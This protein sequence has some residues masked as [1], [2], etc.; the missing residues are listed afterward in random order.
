MDMERKKIIYA[1]LARGLL[2]VTIFL[3][4][5]ALALAIYGRSAPFDGWGFR[6]FPIAVVFPYSAMGILVLARHPG[7]AVG[8]I[9][10][11]GSFFS[12]L[13]GLLFEYMLYGLVLF[14]GRLPGAETVAWILNSYWVWLLMLVVLLLVVFPDGR[15]PSPRWRYFIYASYAGATAGVAGLSFGPGPLTS[16]FAALDNPYALEGLAFP[17]AQVAYFY[18]I[19]FFALAYGISVVGLV[20]RIRRSQGQRRQQFKW[21]AYAAVL[22]LLATPFSGW[23]IK[24]LEFIHMVAILLL[25]VAIAIAILRH[26]LYDIDLLIRRTLVYSLLSAILVSVYF[27]TVVLA[28]NV[29]QGVTGQAGQSPLAVVASTLVIA[30]LFTPLR[31]RIQ[32]LIDRRFFRSKYDTDQILQAFSGAVRDEVDLE[33][34]QDH[35]VSVVDETMQPEVVSLWLQ[36]EDNPSSAGPNPR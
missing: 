33:Q 36:E 1:R 35:L 12:A 21:F 18:V 2:M 31:R 25:P 19:G 13:Q 29:I 3:A 32:D 22:L 8:W 30:A 34:L 26:N 20:S 6:W 7:H 5:V 4:L 15:L 24:F 27:G 28:Q 23:E 9:M 16:S 17:L 11:A 10:L 14:P